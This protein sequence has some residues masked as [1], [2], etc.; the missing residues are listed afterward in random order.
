VQ[1]RRKGKQLGKGGRVGVVEEG[2]DPGRER[3]GM[4]ESRPSFWW[5]MKKREVD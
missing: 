3:W 2:S 1:K 4:K 5:R